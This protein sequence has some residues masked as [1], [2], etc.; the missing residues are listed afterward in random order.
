MERSIRRCLR[1]YAVFV[2]TIPRR[3]VRPVRKAPNHPAL[4]SRSR[5]GLHR[6]GYGAVVKLAFP[7][8][9]YF[10][11]HDFEHSDGH[12]LYRRRDAEGEASRSEIGRASCREV[13]GV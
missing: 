4:Q 12:G 8:T 5:I 1:A 3:F 2:F 7:W 11:N 6:D 9:N 13:G 10:R